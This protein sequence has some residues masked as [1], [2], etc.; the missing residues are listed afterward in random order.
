MSRDSG[1]KLSARKL[2]A[3]FFFRTLYFWTDWHLL[4]QAPVVTY[5]VSALNKGFRCEFFGPALHHAIDLPFPK[6]R[7]RIRFLAFFSPKKRP[8]TLKKR[9]HLLGQALREG[10]PGVDPKHVLTLLVFGSQVLVVPQVPSFI[11]EAQIVPLNYHSYALHT[12]Y[13]TPPNPKTHPEIK[14]NP[15]PP[16]KPKYRKNMKNVRKA[17]YFRIFFVSFLYFGFGG[18]FGVYFGVCFGGLG[19]VLYFVWGVYDHNPELSLG[20]PNGRKEKST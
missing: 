7:A 9:S 14:K 12:K 10:R 13:K 8:K 2:W 15:N 4:G 20:C 6:N 18:G 5:C 1:G 3:D 19:G 11:Q 17:P 16:P